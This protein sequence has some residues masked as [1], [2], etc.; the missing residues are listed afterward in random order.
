MAIAF[1][2]RLARRTPDPRLRLAAYAVALVVLSAIVWTVAGTPSYYTAQARFNLIFYWLLPNSKTPSQDLL[3]LGLSPGDVRYSG[4]NSYSSMTPMND[5]A[6]R[7]YFSS[8]TS[9]SSVLRFYVR[10]PGRPLSKLKSDLWKE[11]PNRRVVYLSNYR[12][13]YGRPAGAR[14]PQLGSWSAL[15]TRMFRWW[16]PHILIWLAAAICLPLF[17][18]RNDNSRLRRSLAWA[19]SIIALLAVAEFLTVSLVDACETDR[20]LTM[21]HIFT[22]IT[23][24]LALVLAASVIRRRPDLAYSSE[25]QRAGTISALRA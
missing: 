8:R 15:R 13:E 25:M 5:A 23:M 12:R 19:I 17:V 4:M 10:H 24:F 1:A 14:D 9:Y 11:A 20:H 21:F 7:D 6:F 18:A 3:E 22:D 2:F 16:P